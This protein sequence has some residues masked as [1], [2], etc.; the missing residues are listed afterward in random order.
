MCWFGRESGIFLWIGVKRRG[1]HE[2]KERE[3]IKNL[4]Y[5]ERKQK[6]K[7]YISRSP[8]K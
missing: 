6:K 1:W 3:D 5:R 4:K 2:V 7:K 8:L